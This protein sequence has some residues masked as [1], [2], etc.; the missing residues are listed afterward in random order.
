M[1]KDLAFCGERDA[2]EHK[3]KSAFWLV[4]REKKG[5]W[6]G[7]GVNWGFGGR[8]R[9]RRQG[10]LDIKVEFQL[11]VFFDRGVG[12]RRRQ[13]QFKTFLTSPFSSFLHC[14]TVYKV[15]SLRPESS[16]KDLVLVTSQ[17]CAGQLRFFKHCTINLGKCQSCA[18]EVG[19]VKVGFVEMSVKEVSAFEIC[20][21]KIA[22]GTVGAVEIDLTK[23]CAHKRSPMQPCIAAFFLSF[24]GTFGEVEV[25]HLCVGK[26]HPAQKHSFVLSVEELCS[27]QMAVGKSALEQVA[28]SK[29]D[30]LKL[31]MT[32]VASIP[33]RMNAGVGKGDIVGAHLFP[34][35]ILHLC[36]FKGRAAEFALLKAHRVQD[37]ILKRGSLQV[38]FFKAD[39]VK[40]R[41]GQIDIFEGEAGKVQV[42]QPCS[43]QVHRAAANGV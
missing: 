25:I 24:G 37:G 13:L 5:G 29:E 10:G 2:F 33:H 21:L 27:L 32:Q 7:G 19:L 34:G 20:T 35:G 12:V 38:D 22:V 3:L 11:K 36:I 15:R 31:T 39:I 17:I 42:S 43:S 8:F 6:A 1:F 23:L 30:P 18:C 28:T 14:L 9:E 41:A 26:I 16:C 40:D 4:E